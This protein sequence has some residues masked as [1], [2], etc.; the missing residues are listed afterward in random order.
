MSRPK[1][2]P[3]AKLAMTMSA[4][5]SVSLCVTDGG[6]TP[7]GV[8][9]SHTCLVIHTPPAA[10]HSFWTLARRPPREEDHRAFVAASPI[11]PSPKQ[12]RR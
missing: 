12:S 8:G 10:L 4:I 5:V 1:A 7:A 3:T 6:A 11:R 9:S 2:I